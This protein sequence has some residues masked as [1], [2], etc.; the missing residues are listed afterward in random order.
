MGAGEWNDVITLP[1]S[2]VQSSDHR[3]KWKGPRVPESS[4]RRTWPGQE[5]LSS[6]PP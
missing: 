1:R 4:A 3:G 2:L 6:G 5:V